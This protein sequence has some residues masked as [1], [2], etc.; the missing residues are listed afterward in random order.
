MKKGWC[1]ISKRNDVRSDLIAL[2]DIG[3]AYAAVTTVVLFK[4]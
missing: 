1:Y 4:K 3:T 2:S